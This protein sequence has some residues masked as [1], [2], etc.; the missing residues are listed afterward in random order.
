MTQLAVGLNKTVQ[1]FKDSYHELKRVVWPTRNEI[2]QHTIIVIAMSVFVALFL[3][4]L[5]IVAAVGLEKILLLK[6]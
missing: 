6:K 3:G 1:Y 5:D 2:T 4:A